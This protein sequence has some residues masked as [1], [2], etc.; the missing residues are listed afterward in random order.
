MKN[1]GRFQEGQKVKLVD[2]RELMSGRIA[3]GFA[4]AM[5]LYFGDTVTI[6]C[7]GTHDAT[8]L[9]FVRVKENGWSWDLR[10][11][12]PLK[13][14]PVSK[15]H[16]I[17]DFIKES[18]ILPIG[19]HLRKVIENDKAVICFVEHRVKRETIKTVAICQDCDEFNIHKG[20]EICMYKT[21]RK[22]ADK[23]LRNF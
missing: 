22:I 2:R 5:N 17:N 1:R 4:P 23:N 13:E 3:K 15:V 8:G 18:Y 11:L 19:Y 14:K 16:D 10:F 21:L 20:I 12:Q 9:D 7:I 6:E